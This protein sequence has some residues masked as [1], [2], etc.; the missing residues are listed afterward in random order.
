ML[1]KIGFSDLEDK[2]EKPPKN[3]DNKTDSQKKML[4]IED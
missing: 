2:P 1:G 3:A 4:D